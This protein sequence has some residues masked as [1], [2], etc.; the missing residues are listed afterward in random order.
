[1]A[2]VR[3]ISPK[4]QEQFVD[5]EQYD[6]GAMVQ[7]GWTRGA[8][9]DSSKVVVKEHVRGKA[10][11]TGGSGA[12]SY[13]GGAVG[14]EIGRKR[15]GPI[16]EVIGAALG[17]GTG[18][19]FTQAANTG[20][21]E[22]FRAAG[23]V[24]GAIADI[25]ANLSEPN[26]SP[27]SAGQALDLMG[28]AAT[29]QALYDMGG[30]LTAGALKAGG[31]AAM[32]AAVR[33]T[34][35]AA[36]TAIREGIAVTKAGVNKLMGKIGE[37]GA[38]TK[39]LVRRAANAGPLGGAR[40][41]TTQLADNVY[42]AVEA[43]L[44]QQGVSQADFI[45]L[46]KIR[47]DFTMNRYNPPTL[48]LS[49]LHEIKQTAG[50]ASASLHEK[51]ARLEPVVPVDPVQQLWDKT[52]ET[53]ANEVL[54]NAVP[55][56]REAN[57]RASQLIALKEII[58]PARQGESIGA[59]AARAATSPGGRAVAG[60]VVGAGLPDQVL[61]GNRF[62]QALEGAAA[63]SLTS[64]QVLSTLALILHNPAILGFARQAPRAVGG[65]YQ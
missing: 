61:P 50:Q 10:K 49:R 39:A 7:D 36:Q 18:E 56:Y 23:P 44:K 17:G 62:Q 13:I 29:N 21:S 8:M 43:E 15:G 2:R 24:G 37:V 34:P 31:K 58:A 9:S 27:T 12:L 25:M 41:P 32:N 1:M 42:S 57:A 14:S 53:R 48:S 35:E 4:G 65:V 54:G 52:M 51:I 45:K 38:Q 64:P 6:V 59:R 40:V 28:N 33:F 5:P 3:L 60:A 11:R 20:V 19:A 63:G 26:K 16:G 30:Q 46:R 55:G 22:S 47:D